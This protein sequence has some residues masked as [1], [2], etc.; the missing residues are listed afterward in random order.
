MSIFDGGRFVGQYQFTPMVAGDD[1]IVNYGDASSVD[2]SR[3]KPSIGRNNDDCIVAVSFVHDDEERK[4]GVKVWRKSLLTTKYMLANN[5]EKPVQR[6]YV[7]HSAFSHNDGYT[8]T[9]TDRAVKSVT[10][11]TRFEFALGVEE[12]REFAVEEEAVYD[13][14]VSAT[15]DLTE[16]AKKIVPG[17]AKSGTV[18]ASFVTELDAFL[19]WRKLKDALVRIK[20]GSVDAAAPLKH[21]FAKDY[22]RTIVQDCETKKRLLG[23]TTAQ[24]REMA[25]NSQ[26]IRNIE[27]VQ[28]RLREN[29]RGFVN[30]VSKSTETILSR[31]VK[32][33]DAQETALVKANEA[34]GR[35]EN[36]TYRLTQMVESISGKIATDCGEALEKV[37]MQ[38]V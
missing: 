37:H 19:E 15:L 10:G 14:N 8:I 16:F 12:E 4:V 36:E 32:D 31:Y 24:K 22:L 25:S 7:D 18:S 13:R 38:T 17:L 11:F 34:I 35:N 1:Q 23:E 5:G 2:V 20:A 26:I 33:L 21:L 29:I 9:T 30:I 27:E 3:V 28:K 6:L